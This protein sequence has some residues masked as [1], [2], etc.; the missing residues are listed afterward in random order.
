[1][2]TIIKTFKTI[3]AIVSLLFALTVLFTIN[4][5]NDITTLIGLA[6]SMIIGFAIGI[7][8]LINIY[9]DSFNEEEE[10]ETIYDE[11]EREIEVLRSKEL[12]YINF[13]VKIRDNYTLNDLFKED[14]NSNIK[15]IKEIK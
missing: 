11:Y 15:R 5:F 14:I 4:N 10:E 13:L 1:M 3:V 7:S 9:P 2:K 6:V 12:E 8:L